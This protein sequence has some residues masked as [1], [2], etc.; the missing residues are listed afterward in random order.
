M[1][2]ENGIQF[3]CYETKE[4]GSAAD[5]Q[6]WV[7]PLNLTKAVTQ[8]KSPK[9]VFKTDNCLMQVHSAILSICTKLP[10]VFQTFVLFNF[11]W[12]LKTGFTVQV[13]T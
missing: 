3:S 13:S 6:V 4:L 5:R 7:N 2:Y 8:K 11:E 10:P 1:K 9:Y 12:L